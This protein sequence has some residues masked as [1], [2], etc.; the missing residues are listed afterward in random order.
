MET[1]YY[2]PKRAGSYGG[3]RPLQKYSARS[4]K[5]VREWLSAQ[6]AYTLHKPVRKIFP[7]R[8]TFSKGIDDLFQA[9]LADLSNLTRYNNGIRYILIVVGQIGL[10][11]VV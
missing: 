8:K 2:D 7:R 10:E 4:T 5:S 9:D 6:D 3:V 11:Q 1:V